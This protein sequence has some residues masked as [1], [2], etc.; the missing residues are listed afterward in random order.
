MLMVIVLPY[1]LKTES[2]YTF[3]R[4]ARSS[5]QRKKVSN[6]WSHDNNNII[7]KNVFCKPKLLKK[8]TTPAGLEP[9]RENPKRFLIFRLN[10]SAIVP[11]L[12]L[13]YFPDLQ[14]PKLQQTKIVI[15]I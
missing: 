12:Y 11:I 1:D 2:A 7:K 5:D 14:E 6:F 10:R 4:G 8:E 15:S 3:K 9:A 13:N